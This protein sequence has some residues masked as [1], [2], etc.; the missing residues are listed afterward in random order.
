MKDEV[1][2][3][4]PE[5]IDVQFV[6]ILAWRIR[7]LF[8]ARRLNDELDEELRSHLDMLTAEYVNKGMTEDDARREARRSFGGVTQTREAYLDQRGLPIVETILQ[9]L[10]YGARMLR[11]NP[12][13]TA[14]AVITLALGIGA[15]T[16]IFSVIDA[17]MIKSLPVKDPNR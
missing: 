10:R 14:V 1:S 4:M 13:F 17:V 5:E 2:S 3:L 8:G 6:R 16:A 11:K 7:G 12:G 9:D 15:N